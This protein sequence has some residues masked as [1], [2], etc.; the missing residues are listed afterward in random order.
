MS[1]DTLARRAGADVRRA[2][3]QMEPTLPDAYDVVRRGDRRRTNVLVALCVLSLVLAGAAFVRSGDGDSGLA[4]VPSPSTSEGGSPASVP[5]GRVSGDV[6]RFDCVVGEDCEGEPADVAVIFYRTADADAD[7]DAD[8]GAG[9]AAAGDDSGDTSGDGSGVTADGGSAETIGDGSGEAAG[10]LVSAVV[11]DD[12]IFSQQ[13][14]AGRWQ[15]FVADIDPLDCTPSS[16][17]VIA[18]QALDLD[19]ECRPSARTR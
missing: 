5:S 16:V 8:A 4:T 14:P 9:A 12:G 3:T 7:A 10:E 18:G 19:I 11:D 13:V 6:V 15:V 17:V 1:L 2:A